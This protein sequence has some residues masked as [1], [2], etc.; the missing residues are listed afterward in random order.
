LS[1]LL[2]NL[3]FMRFVE[4]GSC[5]L[6]LISVHKVRDSGHDPSLREFYI[7]D[8]GVQV[9]EGFSGVEG[10]TTGVAREPASAASNPPTSRPDV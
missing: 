8:R 9:G 5:L 1:A 10:V 3:I 4:R 7:T 2:E 6:R